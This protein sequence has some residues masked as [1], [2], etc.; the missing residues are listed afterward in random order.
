MRHA[1]ARL[2]RHQ[3]ARMK[4]PAGKDTELSRAPFRADPN[5]EQQNAQPQ[6][7]ARRQSNPPKYT[8]GRETVPND[9]MHSGSTAAT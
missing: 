5:A 7:P 2:I 3:G 9:A 8:V 4:N 6:Q 1:A